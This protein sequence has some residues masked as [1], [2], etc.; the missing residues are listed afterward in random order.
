MSRGRAAAIFGCAGPRLAREERDFFRAAD[1]FGFVL[2]ARNVEDPEQLRWL[3][4]ELR[5][6]AGW[7]A[8]VFID[9]EGGRVARLGA[10]HWRQWLPPLDQ[11]AK[12]RRC[13][14]RAMQI[15]YRLIA[16]ELRAVGIDGNLAPVADLAFPDTHPVLRN[17]CFGDDVVAVAD[18][19]AAAAMGLV[20]GGVLPVVKHMPGLGRATADSHETLPRVKAHL[21]K[22]RVSDF[23]A[24]QSVAGLPLGMTAHVVFEALDPEAPATQSPA[25][26]R[27]IRETIGFRGLLMTDD[28]SMGALSGSIAERSRRAL[29]A[30]CDLVL[31]C[32]G[33]PGEMRA[34][35]EAAGGMSAEALIR[36]ED[37]LGWRRDPVPADIAALEAEFEALMHGE[38]LK[39]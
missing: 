7:D 8:P 37:A 31:H 28:I 11:V 27:L 20:E 38:K 21:K 39:H 29:D 3:T 25:A 34:L 36:A 35:A 9:Q 14:A 19:A 12:N 6:A 16:E 32:N 24:F 10:P 33:D 22:L 23:L 15:R 17:R 30:G 1:P 13:A 26:I 2:F 18:I 5:E 4:T